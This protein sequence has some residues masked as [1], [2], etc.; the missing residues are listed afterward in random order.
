MPRDVEVKRANIEVHNKTARVFEEKNIELFNIFEQRSLD[1]RLRKANEAC[2][3]HEFSCDL[4][5]GPGNLVSRQTHVFEH[6]VGL[7]ISREM[8]KVCKSKGLGNKAHFLVADAENLP[9]RD[10]IFDIV[11]MHAALHHL[12][13]PSSCFK[14]IRRIL[15]A[16]GIMY[17]DHEPNSRRIRRPFEKIEKGLYLVGKMLVRKHNNQ[18]SCDV[19]LFPPECWMADIQDAEGFAPECIRMQLES[20]GFRG[21]D[22]KYRNGSSCYFSRLPATLSA[23]SLVDDLLD[24]V[25]FFK[26]LSSQICFR[27][28]K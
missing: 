1:K 22:I 24:D 13:S 20:I 2:K 6:V 15:A 25:P 21:V 14:E 3:K 23:L 8:I 28:R 11:T 12:P 26:H 27:A 4:A 19:P 17:I 9:F 10:G 7:D 5:C 16:E 18:Q